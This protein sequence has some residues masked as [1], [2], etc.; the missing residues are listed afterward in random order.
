MAWH[1]LLDK[2]APQGR[3]FFASLGEPGKVQAGVLSELLQ[4]N[5]NTVFGRRYGFSNIKSIEQYRDQVPL[6]RYEQLLPYINSIVAGE[7]DVL[8][9]DPVTLF[10]ETGGSTAGGKIIPYNRRALRAFQQ[11]IIP[12]LY[13][14]LTHRPGI[15]QGK[16]YWSISPA[17]KTN[18]QTLSGIPC[19]MANDADYFGEAL[20]MDILQGLAVSPQ[21]AA[22]DDFDTWQ[23]LT[24]RS[25]LAAEDLSFI[26]VWSPTF[27]LSLLDAMVAQMPRLLEDMHTGQIPVPL[28]AGFDTSGFVCSAERVEQ[29]GRVVNGD[30]I[31]IARLWPDMDTVSCWLDANAARYESDLCVLFPS[32]YL[33]GKGLLAT[34]GVVSIPVHQADGAVLSLASGVY[35]FIDGRENVYSAAELHEGE[36]YRVVMS[37]YSGFYRYELGDRVTVSGFLDKTPLLCFEGRAGSCSDLCGEKL[38]EPFVL[39]VLNDIPGHTML[40]ADAQDTLGYYLL[41]DSRLHSAIQ[42]D[43][44][45]A[46]VE[47]CLC[48]NP[49]YAY[50]RQL[51]QLAAL[52]P[53]CVEHPWDKYSYYQ[54]ARGRRLGDI[55]P[56]AL[57]ADPDLAG[58]FRDQATKTFPGKDAIHEQAAIFTG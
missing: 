50:A 29:L 44:L 43:E 17:L 37:T 5:A 21:V 48:N 14:L 35:E 39:R 12:W 1:T 34:E 49:Q 33:Q 4:R 3:A 55:K 54:S 11:A 36:S 25:L 52:R 20:A 47:R 56:M 41:L 40:L 9:C 26:S 28:P 16:S 46:R 30:S 51:G 32:A 42:A 58:W 31:D 6:H 13:D 38:S 57:S 53:L 45:A 19:G 18:K 7:A 27:L 24:L 23:Y 2:I 22:A 10:E 8:S 15:M